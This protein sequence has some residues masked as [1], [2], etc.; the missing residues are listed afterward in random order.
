MERISYNDVKLIFFNNL[1]Q[2]FTEEIQ[3]II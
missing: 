1:S 2:Q 3:E